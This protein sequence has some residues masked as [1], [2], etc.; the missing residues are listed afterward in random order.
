MRVVYTGGTFDCLHVGHVAFLARSAE[1]GQLTV[2]LNADDFVERYK[3]KRPVY[4][5][6]ERESHLT[7]L[8][9]VHQVVP[10]FGGEDSRPMIEQVS[11]DY[12]TIGS[13]WARRDYYQQMG[14]DQNWLDERGIAL[15]YLPRL[16]TISTTEI[17]Q[18][19]S[20]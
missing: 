14:F 12:I 3:G 19:M 15:V 1:L 2:A 18:R 13:D 17:K 7:L 11:P 6:A 8:P 16:G 20:Q 9:F 5:Y 4:T 10:N